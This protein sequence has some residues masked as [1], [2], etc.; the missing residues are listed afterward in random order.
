MFVKY[1]LISLFSRSCFSHS[2]PSIFLAFVSTGKLLV[3]PTIIF[4]TCNVVCV[5]L[6]MTDLFFSS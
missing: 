5:K 6:S 1:S 3:P 4:M 2:L